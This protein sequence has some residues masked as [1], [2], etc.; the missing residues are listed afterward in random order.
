VQCQGGKK[1]APVHKP[2]WLRWAVA[3]SSTLDWVHCNDNTCFQHASLVA[4][5]LVRFDPSNPLK[6]L[7]SLAEQW[8]NPSPTQW[9]FKLKPNVKWSDGHPLTARHFI[10]TWEKSLR[11]FKHCP[12]SSILFS[13]VNARA[14]AEG[15]VPFHAVGLSAPNPN[16]LI[17]RLHTPKPNFLLTLCHPATWPSRSEKNAFVTLGPFMLE[18]ST[19]NSTRYVRNP[20]YHGPSAA[21]AGIEIKVVPSENSR[22]ELFFNKEIDLAD[23]TGENLPSLVEGQPGKKT[24]PTSRLVALVVNTSK[25]PFQSAKSRL[26]LQK[27]INREEMIALL[28][29]NYLPAYRVFAYYASSPPS[30]SVKYSQPSARELFAAVHIDPLGL[31]LIEPIP[32][33]FARPVLQFTH[34]RE[35]QD[36]ADNIRAQWIKNLDLRVELTSAEHLNTPTP[37]SLG[38]IELFIDPIDPLSTLE[39]F[40]STGLTNPY[41]WKNRTFDLQLHQA[42]AERTMEGMMEQ[43]ELAEK[44]L[45]AQ[46]SAFIP[47]YLKTKTVMVAEHVKG[48][49]QNP[50]EI[51]DFRDTSI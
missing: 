37:A 50:I 24:F 30:W 9:V 49:R 5:G 2:Q 31:R 15:K 14:F 26:A 20:L 4:E 29:W 51:W 11:N 10:E 38:L 8:E 34:F 45:I 27:A 12:N 39:T 19:D 18:K 23:V 42:L 40:S 21:L 46:E 35:A 36:T 44:I 47:L 25:K 41:H 43:L 1:H 16:I 32:I 22:L 48:L 13:I 3:H 6:V 33:L 7:P 28:K 17:I